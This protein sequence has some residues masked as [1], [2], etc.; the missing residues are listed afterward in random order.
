MG[1]RLVRHHDEPQAVDPPI[2]A[3]RHALRGSKRARKKRDPLIDALIQRIPAKGDYFL[4]DGFLM[5]VRTF[6][7]VCGFD[8][9]VV[10]FGASPHE[11]AR[12]LG[13]VGT[14]GH[15]HAAPPSAPPGPPRQA[16]AGHDYFIAL[17]GTACQRDG[18]PVLI[19]D[20]P[21]DEMIFDYRPVTGDFRDTGS[22]V[23]ADGS[24]GTAGLAPGVSFCGPG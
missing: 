6:A 2:E 19:G 18:T 13:A 21:A 4:R 10:S 12:Q 20:I 7:L 9:L 5:W 3:V 22:I 23:W 14:S 1:A 8:D 15:L 17:D 24:R 11:E 16:H